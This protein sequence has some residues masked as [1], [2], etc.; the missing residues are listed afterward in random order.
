MAPQTVTLRPWQRPQEKGIDLAI[1]LDLVEFVL[2][3]CCDVAVVV[4]L[5]RDLAEIPHALRNLRDHLS[6]PIR[7]EA[8]VPVPDGLRYPKTLEGFHYTHQIDSAAFEL[9]RDTTDYTLS[10]ADWQP[11]DPPAALAESASE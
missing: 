4:S 2:T 10:G 5:D 7:L 8:A 9:V 3:G 11:P 6:R 1:A